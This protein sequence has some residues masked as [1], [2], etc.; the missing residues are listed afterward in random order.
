[1]NGVTAV[2]GADNSGFTPKAA[3]ARGTGPYAVSGTPSVVRARLRELPMIYILILGMALSWTYTVLGYDDPTLYALNLVVILAL[4]GTVALL[5][6]Q[7][8]ISM[9]WL[10][11]I[12]LG[13][14]AMVASLVTFVQYRQMLAY[15]VG[16]DVMLAQ[17]TMKNVVMLTSVLVLTYGLYVPKSWRRVAPVVGT[18]ALLP[19]ATLLVLFLRHRQAMEW[20]GK[21]WN[22]SHTARLALFSFD[23][24]LLLI[25]AA[26]T[27]YG[28]RTISMLR[29]QVAE[30][31]QL[32]QY[33]L[34]QRIGSGGM[35][36][37]YLAEHQFLKRPAP[38]S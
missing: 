37:V 21:G 11:A 7:L 34:R 26:G 18:L 10:K 38:S 6:S 5:A 30:A 33:R 27:A 4:G 8:P 19:F 13:V 35:G 24:M 29:R 1:M 20:L 22:W 23:A 28:A 16:R 3:I 12:E 15:S 9:A 14:I 2:G 31:R 17:L 32:G 36:E 25:V